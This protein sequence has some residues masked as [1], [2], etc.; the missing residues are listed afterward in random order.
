MVGS[1]SIY[2]AA[3]P[4][5][6]G[7]RRTIETRSFHT[8]TSVIEHI[9][10][11][12]EVDQVDDQEATSRPSLK[13]ARPRSFADLSK[14]STAQPSKRGHTTEEGHD[15]TST[16]TA[17]FPIPIPIH[18][19][20]QPNLN[21]SSSSTY[22]FRPIPINDLVPLSTPPDLEGAS[23]LRARQAAHTPRTPPRDLTDLFLRK[24]SPSPESKK[25]PGE[26][27]RQPQ[28]GDLL[29]LGKMDQQ[30]G[31][32][33]NVSDSSGVTRPGPSRKGRRKMMTRT[34]SLGEQDDLFSAQ[35]ARRGEDDTRRVLPVVVDTWELASPERTDLRLAGSGPNSPA[36][37][38]PTTPRKIGQTIPFQSPSGREL[39]TPSPPRRQTGIGRTGSLP[40]SPSGKTA[41]R[42]SLS[43]NATLSGLSGTSASGSGSGVGGPGRPIR[44]Y[45]R[46]QATP[47][48]PGQS[49]PNRVIQQPRSSLKMETI[50]SDPP[51]D[52]LESEV[53]GFLLSSPQA[54]SILRPLG[55][56]A[57][58]VQEDSYAEL[59]KRFGV[60][61]EE[62]DD[63][64]PD[65][66]G[67][68]G[69]SG[70]IPFFS[71]SQM[72]RV[73]ADSSIYR[74]PGS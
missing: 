63:F 41:L 34:E 53:K 39:K 43:T 10:Q 46:R 64:D 8:M 70:V 19:P 69:V 22:S 56:R 2:N 44:T 55:N 29:G 12:Q 25:Q 65:S 32:M 67:S 58:P 48:D 42:H 6:S 15:E 50:F 28:R 59:N 21:T 7:N 9:D 30:A 24:P 18:I 31:S 5:S 54:N 72:S 17:S 49:G 14:H 37:E 16:T 26:Q 38:S 71:L 20:S 13:R 66:Q 23:L 3:L 73:D 35:R 62:E 45:G 1:T 4:G 74:L 51:S 40:D 57:V 33:T 11:T 52:G 47:D 61:V 60:D 27:D 68:L 36:A